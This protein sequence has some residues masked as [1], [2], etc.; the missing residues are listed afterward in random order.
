M[1]PLTVCWCRGSSAEGRTCFSASFN[2]EAYASSVA[3]SSASLLVAASGSNWSVKLTYPFRVE[4]SLENDRSASSRSW[5]TRA[6][7]LFFLIEQKA[8][9][10]AKRRDLCDLRDL[11]SR[12]LE[13]N[14][15]PRSTLFRIKPCWK[16]MGCAYRAS[17]G[18]AAF[19]Q[20]RNRI[21]KSANRCVVCPSRSVRPSVSE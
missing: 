14:A 21:L 2:S 9:K 4:R 10:Y 13:R 19:G 12:I 8:A 5:I 3:K 1:M 7:H 11:L 6:C 16:S 15:E 17:G 20:E 18:E